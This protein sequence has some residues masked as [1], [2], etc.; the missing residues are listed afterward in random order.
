MKIVHIAICTPHRCGL[1]ESTREIVAAERA[2]GY[3][4]RVFDPAPTQFYPKT[5]EDRGALLCDKAFVESADLIIDHSGCDGITNQLKTPHIL[6]AH[7]RPKHSF[8]SE[9]NGKPPIYSY[10]L[11]CDASDKYKAVVT[12]WPEHVGYLK[13]MFRKTPVYSVQPTVDL[14]AWS[15]GGPSGYQF[16]GKAGIFNA[17]ITDAWRDDVD[18]F[19]AVNACALAAREIPGFKVHIYGKQGGAKGWPAL[20]KV[21]DEDGSL[22]EVCGW[23]LGLAN[24]YRAASCLVTPHTIY[25]R[26]IREALACGCP[27]VSGCGDLTKAVA[28][29]KVQIRGSRV[30]AREKAELLFN[31]I[32]SAKALLAIAESVVK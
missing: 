21:L 32:N 23:T 16:H 2:L 27:V 19:E 10:H 5:P 20:L 11:R 9:V 30:G 3:D 24:V 17:V 12:F 25:T 28:D 7:G 13:V 22:G 1:W 4:A 8:L 26:S 31:P 29:I 14:K 6:V 18:P 15:P